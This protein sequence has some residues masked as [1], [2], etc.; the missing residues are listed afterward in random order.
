MPSANVDA[1]L[2]PQLVRVEGLAAAAEPIVITI[3]R[4]Y[5]DG[6]L[7]SAEAADRLGGQALVSD[8]GSFVAFIERRRTRVLAYPLGRQLAHAMLDRTGLAG[9]RTLFVAHPFRLQ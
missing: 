7:T 2:A 6:R 1:A 9:I 5:L 4:D 3:A 8:P